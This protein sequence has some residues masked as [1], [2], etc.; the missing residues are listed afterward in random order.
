VNKHFLNTSHQSQD[1]MERSRR[2]LENLNNM[3]LSIT[4]KENLS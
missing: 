3:S 1:L 2:N 4:W